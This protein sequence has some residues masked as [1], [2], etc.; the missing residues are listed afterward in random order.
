MFDLSLLGQIFVFPKEVPLLNPPFGFGTIIALIALKK[1]ISFIIGN[2]VGGPGKTPYAIAAYPVFMGATA[3]ALPAILSYLDIGRSFEPL[4]MIRHG[5]ELL[6]GMVPLLVVW[7]VLYIVTQLPLVI[8]MTKMGEV[9][10]SIDSWVTGPLFEELFHRYFLM[11]MLIAAGAGLAEALF[12]QAFVFSIHHLL[13]GIGGL[14]GG[15]GWSGP[16]AMNH[17]FFGGLAYGILAVKYG[18]IIAWVAH[19]ISNVFGDL[20]YKLFGGGEE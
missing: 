10:K 20:E 9:T 18:F 16:Y 17:T 6:S 12:L 3:F 14:G 4:E 5:I 2:L 13:Q 19:G 1:V 7:F 15:K 11:G 8:I